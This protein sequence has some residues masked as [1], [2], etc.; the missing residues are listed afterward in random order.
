MTLAHHEIWTLWQGFSSHD[1]QG[2]LN[3]QQLY[4]LRKEDGHNHTLS[5]C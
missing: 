2:Q 1:V 4:R 5:E 3:A